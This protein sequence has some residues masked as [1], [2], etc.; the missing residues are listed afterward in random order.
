MINDEQIRQLKHDAAN[1]GEP[2]TVTG[3]LMVL[4]ELEFF[5]GIVRDFAKEETIG[6]SPARNWWFCRYC[7]AYHVVRESIV[8]AETCTWRRATEATK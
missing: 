2:L 5:R 3:T 7:R 8:H 1:K 6:F 4:E